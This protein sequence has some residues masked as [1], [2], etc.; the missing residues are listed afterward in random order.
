MFWKRD[1]SISYKTKL[2]LRFKFRKSGQK[3]IFTRFCKKYN[4]FHI[5]THSNSKFCIKRSP[6]L[7]KI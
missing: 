4:F 6:R 2:Q 3:F 7:R 1:K 5:A